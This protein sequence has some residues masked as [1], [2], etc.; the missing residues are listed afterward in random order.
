MLL[1]GPG[2]R[3]GVAGQKA[4][5]GPHSLTTPSLLLPEWGTFLAENV[6]RGG[7]AMWPLPPDAGPQ[8]RAS[9]DVS[10]VLPGV[11]YGE[12]IGPCVKG[13]ESLG[14]RSGCSCNAP[15][16]TKAVSPPEKAL[17]HAG[18]RSHRPGAT[19]LHLQQTPCSNSSPPAP[20]TVPV[21]TPVA[22]WDSRKWPHTLSGQSPRTHPTPA[23]RTS[24]PAPA[25]PTL[26]LT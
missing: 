21:P 20:P 4:S 16:T 26:T 9:A 13:W 1:A 11:S 23:Q 10:R 8:L 22:A 24:K 6:E 12:H 3:P 7:G 15:G 19:V 17:T 18:G 2:L 25:V 14:R 5:W